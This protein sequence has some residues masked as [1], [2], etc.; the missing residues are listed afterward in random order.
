M[1]CALLLNIPFSNCSLESNESHPLDASP[2]ATSSVVYPVKPVLN[3]CFVTLEII[4]NGQ[5]QDI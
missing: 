4:S 2:D 1:A 5:M 3:F